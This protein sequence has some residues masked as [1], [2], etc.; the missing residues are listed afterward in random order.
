MSHL[1]ADVAALVDGQLS[2]EREATARQH[3]ADCARCRAAVAEQE[4]LKRRMGRSG[5]PGVPREL[6]RSLAALADEPLPAETSPSRLLRP[7]GV[8]AVLTG[9]SMAVLALAYL[10]APGPDRDGDPV[11]PDVE[12]YVAQFVADTA[13]E[14]SPHVPA[15]TVTAGLALSDDRLAQ[16]QADGWPCHETL[17]G[18]LRRLDGH[19]VDSRTA[20]SLRYGDGRVR[21]HLVEQ[22]GSVDHAALDGFRSATVAE[23]SVLVRD[24]VPTV[25]TWDA[26]GVVY[27][28]VTDAGWRR[29]EDVVDQLPTT[30]AREVPER[31]DEGLHRMTSWVT[32]R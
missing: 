12:A 6:A 30:P 7:I 21:L 4:Q 28:I 18:D 11:R 3:L 14:R 20:V 29:I 1:G 10:L 9:A 26:D 15:E 23:S 22:V 27:T 25:V 8:V 32:G 5:A 19:L 16:L 17:A 2:P 13:R 24:G 31:I